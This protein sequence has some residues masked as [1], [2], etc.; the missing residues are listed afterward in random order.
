MKFSLL[1]TIAIIYIVLF[2]I[3]WSKTNFQTISGTNYSLGDEG[4]YIQFSKNIQNG[5]Y[6]KKGPD[7]NLWFTPG[8]PL[9]LS[10]ISLI[11]DDILF[12]RCTSFIFIFL[13]YIILS[14]LIKKETNISIIP[15]LVMGTIIMPWST[16]AIDFFLVHT[17]S[18]IFLLFTL[19][20]YF[21][22]ELRRNNSKLNLY[23]AGLIL[24]F[25]ALTKV[26][27]IYIIIIVA[28]LLLLLKWIFK[29]EIKPLINIHIISL[30]LII[31][32]LI[33]TFY[34]T[35]KVFFTSSSGGLQ[36][37]YM[38]TPVNTKEYNWMTPEEAKKS[39]YHNKIFRILDSVK[40]DQIEFDTYLK[41]VSKNNILRNP[42]DYLKKI[43]LNPGRLFGYRFDSY[44]LLSIL[45][46]FKYYF[47]FV[48]YILTILFSISKGF[49][50]LDFY[51]NWILLFICIYLGLSL[52]LTANLRFFLIT[53]PVFYFLTLKNY[54]LIIR[55][56][57]YQA[58]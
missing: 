56:K 53:F 9:A 30:V 10:I 58:H 51:E 41:N 49:K 36:L 43:L 44:S 32:Y 40:M 28:I 16:D 29:F 20:L 7:V 38:T 8:Y 4:A 22:F 19:L 14:F 18:F 24:G 5:F 12:L 2:W 25:I 37:Y 23:I 17:E 27:F 33:Y 1:K 42:F 35:G 47:L 55:P 13:S 34:I 45:L 21:V 11:S 48:T 39:P 57:L 3:I 26:F 31:P 6:S 15:I 46:C 54:Y 50:N 52:F